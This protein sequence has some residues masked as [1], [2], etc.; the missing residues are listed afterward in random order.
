MSFTPRILAAAHD[1]RSLI[2]ISP[3]WSG[4]CSLVPEPPVVTRQ[5]TTSRP[6]RAQRATLPPIVNSLSSGCAEMQRMRASSGVSVCGLRALSAIATSYRLSPHAERRWP[7][8]PERRGEIGE[9]AEK[10]PRVTRVDD[11]LD[12]EGLGRAKRRAELVQPVLD[13]RHLRLPVG[14]CVEIGTIGRLDPALE[15]QGAPP[16]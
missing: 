1:S 14:C 7:R 13:L 10:R 9:L 16:T 2:G 5:N 4:V 3:V 6:S 12:P 15:R 11:L 8:P